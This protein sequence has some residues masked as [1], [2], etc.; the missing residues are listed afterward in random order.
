MLGKIQL[1]VSVRLQLNDLYS[2]RLLFVPVRLHTTF[3]GDQTTK[4]TPGQNPL[5]N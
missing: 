4:M 2:K 3:A 1:N 5:I